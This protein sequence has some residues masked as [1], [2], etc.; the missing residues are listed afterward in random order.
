M[1]NNSAVRKGQLAEL[2]TALNIEINNAALL[3]NAL[4]H[5]S[6]AH[7]A[8]TMPRPVHNERLE[9]L[10]DSVLS[11]VVCTYIYSNFPEMAEGA[12]TKL[13]ARV[14]C[15][16]A[17]SQYARGINLGKYILLGKG[18]EASG[19]RNRNS[20]LA[21]AF[22]AVI[23]ACYIDQGWEKTNQM[24]LAILQA[25]MDACAV[26]DGV[27]DYK[28]KLQEIVQRDSESAVSYTL[29]AEDGPDH[30]KIFKM[31][32]LINDKTVGHGEG[33]SKKEAE[34]IAAKRALEAMG[35]L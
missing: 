29:I 12:M 10:G 3:E 6:Y 31:A 26:S 24:A 14:V 35:E 11:L 28:T 20:I 34:Q 4:T 15:E 17:L 23:G 19:G 7:E 30:H 1:Q 8:K 32:A 18:E 16:A 27:F 2:C 13:R 25:E 22:E 33:R 5:T 21:D 9:F